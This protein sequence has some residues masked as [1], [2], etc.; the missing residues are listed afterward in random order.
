MVL[1]VLSPEV[2]QTLLAEMRAG[3][4][5]EYGDRLRGLYLYGSYARGDQDKESDVDVLIVLDEIQGYG[6]EV[7]RAA[8]LTSDLSLRYDISI[9]PV[10]VTAKNWLQ[11]DSC[12]L[13]NVRP[14]AVPV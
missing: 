13:A 3:L 8:Q 10:F 9:S 6:S 1:T 2:L 14:E 12:F 7:D 4:E 5:V 11:A